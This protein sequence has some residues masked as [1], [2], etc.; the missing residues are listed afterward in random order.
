MCLIFFI[1]LINLV[2]ALETTI[3]MN[4]NDSVNFNGKTLT[5]LKAGDNWKLKVDVDGVQGI[6]V[7]RNENSSTEINGMIIKILNYTYVDY[8]YIEARL[9]LIVPFKCGDGICNESEETSL[10]CCKDCG[11]GNNQTCVSNICY[12]SECENTSDCE[13]QDPCTI[14]ECSESLP[15]K[16]IHNPVNACIQ[17]DGCCPENCGPNEDIDCNLSVSKIK[18]PEKLGGENNTSNKESIFNKTPEI[19]EASEIKPLEENIQSDIFVVLGVALVIILL[20][21][22]LFIKKS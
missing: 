14:D 9:R 18:P 2:L 11:C 7:Q 6:V 19:N 4:I 21:Y 15:R 17:G 22:F 5:I 10:T 16:C 20:G 12:S 13:D 1:F 3:T 8:D